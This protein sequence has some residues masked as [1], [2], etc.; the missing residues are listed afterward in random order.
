MDNWDDFRFLL[1]LH[2]S[3]T[4]GAAA[5]DLGTN[6][7]TVSRRIERL[8]ES[9]GAPT[10]KKTGNGWQLTETGQLFLPLAERLEAALETDRN[11]RR[12]RDGIS[13]T[14]TLAA[15]PMVFTGILIPQMHNILSQH[16]DL[17][18]NLINRVNVQGLGDADIMIRYERPVQGRLITRRLG[19]VTYRAYRSTACPNPVDGWVSL[20][21]KYDLAPQA[22]FGQ[23]RFG[24]QPRV[25]AEL[26]EQKFAIM[27]S[28]GMQAILPDWIADVQPDIVP[29]DEDD[30]SL[31]LDVWVAYHDTRRQDVA[32][33]ATVEWL[34][35]CFRRSGLNRAD[36]ESASGDQPDD[37][38]G[39]ESEISA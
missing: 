26:Y 17:S 18:L 36:I 8:N 33:A 2:R 7:T 32:I 34:V 15:P 30:E 27:R 6:I 12:S 1:A 14:L 10:F 25:T 21:K 20:G 24:T 3:Q 11:N 13:A 4:M 37:T 35:Q 31:R 22:R 23:R 5:Q 39:P 29:I 19:E 38:S 9:I 16:P 28:T